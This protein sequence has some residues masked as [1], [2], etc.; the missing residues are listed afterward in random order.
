MRIKH[1]HLIMIALVAALAVSIGGCKTTPDIE[2][3]KGNEP[4]SLEELEGV[5]KGHGE[6]NLVTSNTTCD[7]N[8]PI[9]F[10]VKEGKAVSICNMDWCKFDVHITAGGKLRF[11]YRKALTYT[12]DFGGEEKRDVVFKGQL[13]GDKG[14]GT[15]AAGICP[16]KWKVYKDVDKPGHYS[17]DSHTFSK[18]LPKYVQIKKE[19]VITESGEPKFTVHKGDKVKVLESRTCKSGRGECWKIRDPKTQLTGY[20]LARELKINHKPV[21]ED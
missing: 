8:F 11:K 6:S 9:Q 2:T 4:V 10:V 19:L 14:K 16:G 13:I 21:Y 1:A 3:A 17:L 20:I 18:E 7:V 5:W 15:F 12:S